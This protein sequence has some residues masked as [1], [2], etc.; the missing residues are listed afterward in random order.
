MAHFFHRFDSGVFPDLSYSP[1]DI[2]RFYVSPDRLEECV[3]LCSPDYL[4]G[5]P[6]DFPGYPVISL[7]EAT[8]TLPRVSRVTVLVDP[9]SVKSSDL[10]KLKK[11]CRVYLH[12]LVYIET[13]CIRFSENDLAVRYDT[14]PHLIRRA[15]INAG[16]LVNRKQVMVITERGKKYVY[17]CCSRETLWQGLPD[18]FAELKPFL[19]T[20]D[21]S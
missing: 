18:F 13:D 14:K 20:E 10:G 6:S 5:F 8:Q 4:F 11:L 7:Y 3:K 15:L 19:V 9:N 12:R 1:G 21:N 17:D 16:F 2:L